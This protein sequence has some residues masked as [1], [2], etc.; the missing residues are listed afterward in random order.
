MAYSLKRIGRQAHKIGLFDEVLLY[1]P[2]DVPKN[3]LESPLF[4]HKKGAGYWCWKPAIIE[5]TL[6]RFND[7][8]VVIYV[9]AGCTIRRSPQWLEYLK[10]MDQYDT[11]CFHYDEYQPQW[12]KWGSESAKNKYWTKK[13]TLDFM[14]NYVGDSTIGELLQ[15]WGGLVLMKNKDNTVLKQWK[16]LIIQNPELVT[17]PTAEELLDQYPGFAGHRHDQSILTPLAYAD[18][19]TMIVPEVSEKYNRRSFIWASRCRAAN[20]KDFLVWKIKMDTRHLLGDEMIEKL[21]RIKSNV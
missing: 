1:S 4:K 21:K 3:I 8:D 5:M 17:D 16:N 20:F 15:I 14:A 10:Y 12:K 13:Y 11:L 2:K 18:S 6:N 19:N 7:G 9:D